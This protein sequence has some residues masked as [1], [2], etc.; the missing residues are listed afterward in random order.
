MCP[1]MIWGIL[2]SVQLTRNSN[3]GN[4]FFCYYGWHSSVVAS[5]CAIHPS[6]PGSI[7]DC[8][9]MMRAPILKLISRFSIVSFVYLGYDPLV[10]PE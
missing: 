3:T 2:Y 5:V 1:F 6:Y 4:G 7:A 8:F 10:I 9:V